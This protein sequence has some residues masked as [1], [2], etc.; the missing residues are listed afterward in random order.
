MWSESE[1][2]ISEG[3]VLQCLLVGTTFKPEKSGRPNDQMWF[4]VLRELEYTEEEYRHIFETNLFSLIEISRQALPLLKNSGAASV[5]N[6]A[7][8]AGS[9]DIQ[10]GAPY[11]MTKSSII[12]LTRNLAASLGA[13]NIRVN[14]IAPGYIRSGPRVEAIWNSRDPGLILRSI[15]LGRRGESSEIAAATVFLASDAAAYITG[16]TLDVNGGLLC[17]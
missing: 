15:A 12:Q 16:A 10:S 11:G 7:S 3:E 14:A 2:Q 17:L 6:L 8:V 5:I 1:E 13:D 9:F 4:M